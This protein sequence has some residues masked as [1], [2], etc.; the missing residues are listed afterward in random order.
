MFLSEQQADYEETLELAFESVDA[1]IT[2]QA[3]LVRDQRLWVNRQE[4]NASNLIGF[5][6][7]D[8][9]GWTLLGECGWIF[10][11]YTGLNQTRIS[12]KVLQPSGED[13]EKYCSANSALLLDDLYG[14]SADQIRTLQKTQAFEKLIAGRQKML[15]SF[16]TPISAKLMEQ[17]QSLAKALQPEPG[18]HTISSGRPGLSNDELLRRLALVLLEKRL[19]QK[20]PGLTRGEFVF[21][22]QQKLKIPLEMHTIKNAAKLLAHAQKNDEQT[23]L[24]MAEKMAVEWQKQFE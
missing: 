22:V 20:D 19:K 9:N 8:E 14:L 11:Q 24:S 12:F 5:Q 6:V 13:I 10:V 3:F 21:L 4:F 15:R 17:A 7:F 18:S 23:V 2:R 1:E 16:Y